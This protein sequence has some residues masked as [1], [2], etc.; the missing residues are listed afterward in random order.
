MAFGAN[1][2]A[3]L[4]AE[5]P[6]PP[7]SAEAAAAVKPDWAEGWSIARIT[8]PSSGDIRGAFVELRSPA[9]REVKL[10]EGVLSKE[11]VTIRKIEWAGAPIRASVTIGKGEESALLFADARLVARNDDLHQRLSQIEIEVKF[12]EMPNG[13]AEKSFLSGGEKFEPG[14]ARV[15][16]VLTKETAEMVLQGLAKEKGVDIA[17][18]PRVTTKSQQRAVIEVIREVVYA[19]AWNPP[20]ADHKN[21]TPK[22]RETR[23]VGFTS[24]SNQ[25]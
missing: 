2:A 4:P 6:E 13:F 18:A 11:G 16:G 19:T 15:V 17:A 1:E 8:I 5:K 10:T 24:R 22:S 14:V 20:D 3:V 7:A 21:G 25:S 9:G 12:I 23:N